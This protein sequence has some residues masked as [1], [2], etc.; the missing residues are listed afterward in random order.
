[1]TSR[2]EKKVRQVI[3]EQGFVV[4]ERDEQLIRERLNNGRRYFYIVL[5][6]NENGQVIHRFL[7]IPE[8]NTKKLLTPF[9]RQILI[10]QYL[11]QHNIIL[12]RD[13]I[14][15][16]DDPKKGT[17]F[18]IMETFPEGHSRIGFIE[19]FAKAEQLTAAHARNVITALTKFHAIR[20]HDLPEHLRT[21]LKP[22][23]TDFR[24]VS[25]KITKFLN[26]KVEPADE[27]QPIVLAALLEKRLNIID[28]KK[29]VVQALKKIKPIIFDPQNHGHA[30]VHGDMAP[31]N[32]Y[33]FDND[34]I[35]LLDL[36]WV[37]SST[38]T[39][40]A[41]VIDYGNMRG[42]AWNNLAFQEALDAEILAYYESHGQP[43]LGKA[44]VSLA[45]LHTHIVFAGFFE[46][47]KREKQAEPLQVERKNKTEQAI[48][49]ALELLNIQ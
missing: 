13:V 9:V 17:P 24:V 14:S 40:M 49:K 37:G 7:K 8:N 39:V 6:R 48:K 21:I 28:I 30:L 22:F 20:P 41:M 10:A 27:A 32:L 44:V 11:K 1:M 18:A 25:S 23:K 35:E 2:Y 38:N 46:N 42:R 43:E 26:M 45:I 36:E 16:N 33:V 47:Y 4:S 5:P 29:K 15:F 31:N 34:D 19:G 3:A 12:T